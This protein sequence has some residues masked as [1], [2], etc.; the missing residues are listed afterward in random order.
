F[1]PCNIQLI[2]S[3]LQLAAQGKFNTSFETLVGYDDF[4]QKVNF[5][6]DLVCKIE[7]GNRFMAA[8]ATNSDAYNHDLGGQRREKREA[9]GEFEWSSGTE[10][11]WHSV[12]ST[13]L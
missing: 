2:A 3:K 5:R 4:A 8:Y 7:L 13:F 9:N 11:S 1:Q 6:G 10:D 12:H